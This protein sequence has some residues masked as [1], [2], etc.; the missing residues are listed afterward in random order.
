MSVSG[1]RGRVIMGYILD[2]DPENLWLG[3]KKFD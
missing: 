2:D 3:L 1:K